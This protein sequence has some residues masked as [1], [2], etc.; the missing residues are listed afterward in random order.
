MERIQY[1]HYNKPLTLEAGSVLPEVTIAYHTFGQLN[2]DGTNVVWICHALT[3]N[4]NVLEWWPGIVGPGCP[5]DPARHFIVC[6]NILGSCYGTTGPASMNPATGEPYYKDF[7][8][9]TIRDM[10]SVH[11]LL[12]DHLGIHRIFLLVGGSM[13]G[14]QALEWSVM[15]PERVDRLFLI[16]TAARETPWGIAIHT[17]QR[18][19]IEADHTW[20]Q[21]DPRA[22]EKGLKAARA[23][24]MLTYRNYDTYARTQ[25]DPDQDKLD[26]F[27]A[28]GY[29]HHQGNKL[30]KRFNAYTYWIL[31]KA[32]DNHNLA[33]KR[34]EDVSMVLKTIQQKTLVIGI[35][36]DL[37]CPLRELE[38]LAGHIPHSRFHVIESHYGHDGFLTEH[39]AIAQ[40]LTNWL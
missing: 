28:S 33:R 19:A 3:A 25:S 10:V 20:G 37:L 9:I 27:R 29:I 34:A 2:E 23:I 6:A 32:M 36:N 14:Y 30:I 4:S 38:F 16:A 40:Y 31:S 35:H 12:R 18:I 24:A 26:D 11:Q 22:G 1:F 13:G 17:A 5:I 39:K 8:L 15:E 21:P 7:P